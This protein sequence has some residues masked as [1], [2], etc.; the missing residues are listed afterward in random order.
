MAK[1]EHRPEEA[2]AEA[3]AR[4][5]KQTVMGLLLLL[6]LVIGSSSAAVVVASLVLRPQAAD[7]E[8]EATAAAAPEPEAEEDPQEFTFEKEIIVNVYGTEQ[9][10]YLSVKPVFEVRDKATL[11]EITDRAGEV[12]NLLIGILKSKTLTELDDPEITGSLGREILELTN[13]QLEFGGRVLRVYFTQLVV[14]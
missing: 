8:T 6:G 10:R 12:Q 4:S 14:Q 13:T 3:P 2:A 9:R 5:G 7:A 11:E 1:E